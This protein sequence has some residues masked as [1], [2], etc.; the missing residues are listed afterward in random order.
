MKT[1][2]SSSFTD[3]TVICKNCKKE[4]LKL[5]KIMNTKEWSKDSLR[6]ITTHSWCE[7]C[8]APMAYKYKFIELENGEIR[9]K[10]KKYLPVDEVFYKAQSQKRVGITVRPKLRTR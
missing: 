1:N 9:A 5:V 10:I 2:S 8:G 6:S 3:L 4:V 7:N